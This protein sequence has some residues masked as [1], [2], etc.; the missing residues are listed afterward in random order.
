MKK[1]NIVL[2][3]LM[4]IL[5]TG[6]CITTAYAETTEDGNFEYTESENSITIDKYTGTAERVT[7]PA[8]INGKPVIAIKGK[9][10]S[11]NPDIKEVKLPD[12]L[13]EIG[14]CAFKDCSFLKKINIPDGVKILEDGTFQNCIALYDV[15]LGLG[16]ESIREKAFSGCTSLDIV[17]L[18]DSVT[19]IE[20]DAFSGC[21]KLQ[22]VELSKNLKDICPNAFSGCISLEEISLPQG[23]ETIGG[24]AFSD[25]SN[26][27]SIAVPDSVEVIGPYAFNKCTKLREALLMANVKTIEEGIF[28]NCTS[29]EDVKLPEGLE[30]MGGSM[31]YGCSKLSAIDLP[32]SVKIIGGA[33]FMDC[34]SLKDV[35]IPEN[36][37]ELGNDAFSGCTSLAEIRLPESIES[38][39]QG[40]FENCSALT[41]ADMSPGLKKIGMYA[42]R[43]CQNLKEIYFSPVLESVGS[44][45]FEWCESLKDV[46]VCNLDHYDTVQFGEGASDPTSI[47]RV[48]VH[49]PL[50]LTDVEFAGLNFIY[51]GMEHTVEPLSKSLSFDDITYD[52]LIIT[53]PG[54]YELTVKSAD[55]KTCY[56][57]KT[58]K[59][60]M[61]RKQL[62]KDDVTI[63]G[64]E[65]LTYTGKA[66][67]QS[68]IVKLG[69]QELTEGTDYRVY[70]DDNVD[71]GEAKV[72]IYFKGNYS[73]S[74][75]DLTFNILPA[76]A[77][78]AIS[79]KPYIYTGKDI[80]PTVTARNADGILINASEYTVRY[81]KNKAV[82]K[83]VAK[84]EFKGNYYTDKVTLNFKI[85]PAAAKLSTLTAGKKKLTVKM[86][87]SPSAKGGS[88]Y[89]IAYKQKGTSKWKY[90]T[91]TK[92]SKTIKRLKKGKKYY[93]KVR[94]YKTANSTKYYG[95]WTRTKLSST[96]K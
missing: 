6:L 71:A 33:A 45:A 88:R 4:L 22:E 62:E 76:K 82:G 16:L 53:E 89:Q 2:M 38:I 13:I 77:T 24:G 83:A 73:G 37:E 39:G 44:D 15:G 21:E 58:L 43:D 60:T 19:V 66:L 94:A 20:G 74:I 64:I 30:V 8:E 57:E 93:V 32:D 14:K 96:I 48:V 42:F 81:S 49:A 1:R 87:S 61:S 85:N 78:C 40:C 46:Y 29:L 28:F 12:S 68:P 25:C 3:I 23:L 31:F 17:L 9:A 72:S 18:P 35:T 91:T 86:S 90:T 34:Q 55:P 95:A 11:G 26:L 59:I 84:V 36:V 7:V 52:K 75:D 70:Y 27:A 79:S 69:E 80:K 51:D 54:I 67:K 65:D 92:Q 47:E 10:F 63:S 56:G 5:C 50:N 41:S